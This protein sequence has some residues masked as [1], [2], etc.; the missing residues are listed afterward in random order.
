[1]TLA[2]LIGLADELRPNTLSNELKTRWVNEAE[3]LVQTEIFL[4]APDDIVSYTWDD[5]QESELLV[6]P[7]HEKLYLPYLCAQIDFAHREY[8]DYQNDKAMFEEHFGEF[9]RWFSRNYRPAD[10]H[11]PWYVA[12]TTGGGDE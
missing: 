5:D 10:R 1:M 6:Q 8:E 7:P 12:A 9:S 2:E 11:A 3:G 4:M